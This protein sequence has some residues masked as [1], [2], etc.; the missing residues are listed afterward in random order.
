MTILEQVDAYRE[1]LD[2]KE[3][4]ADATKENN[5]ALEEARNAL[6]QAMIDEETPQI[7]RLGYS[8]SVALKTKYSKRSGADQLLMDTLRDF[9]LGDLIKETVNAQSLQGA[10]SNLAAENDDQLPDEF[11]DCVNTYEF[12]DVTRRKAAK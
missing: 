12:Y 7:E 8:Y 1:L 3:R 6:A 9:G 4:L 2:K 11:Q 5:K 10:M